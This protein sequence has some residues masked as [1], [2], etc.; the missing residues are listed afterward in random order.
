VWRVPLLPDGGVTRVGIFIQLSGS[1]GGPDGLAVDA[2]GSL[3]IAHAGLGTV[4]LVS[5]IGEPLLRI[6]STAGLMTTN[7]AY[8]GPGRRALYVTE[9]HSGSI[10]VVT[11]DVP[12]LALYS[13]A[14]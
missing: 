6:R 3:A 2:Q 5:R 13:H 10:L 12:G 11:L 4:W 9:S 8:G 14:E 7:V 1:L